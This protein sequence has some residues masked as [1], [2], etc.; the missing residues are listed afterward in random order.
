MSAGL[1][2]DWKRVLVGGRGGVEEHENEEGEDH[3][4][5]VGRKRKVAKK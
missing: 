5:E 2:N 1:K 4:L 3:G